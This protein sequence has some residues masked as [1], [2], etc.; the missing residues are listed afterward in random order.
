MAAP[1]IL[2][3]L[4]SAL[5]AVGAPRAPYEMKL[6]DMLPGAAID[7]TSSFVIPAHLQSVYYQKGVAVSEDDLDPER[8]SCR[9]LLHSRVEYARVLTRGRKINISRPPHL[10]NSNEVF[11]GELPVTVYYVD[12]ETP[13]DETVSSITCRTRGRPP[14]VSDLQAS[15]GDSVAV[16]ISPKQEAGFRKEGSATT[17]TP[18]ARQ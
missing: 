12:F 14:T 5:I 9:V 1:G 2:A 4:T 10:T 11:E 6:A 7:V 16:E 13:S 17:R 8:P 3:F 15:L 18:A